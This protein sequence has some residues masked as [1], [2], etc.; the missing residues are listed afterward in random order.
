[1]LTHLP[2]L[3]LRWSST[4]WLTGQAVKVDELSNT[5]SE[6]ENETLVYIVTDNLAEFA[7]ETLGYTP[8][9]VGL[10]GWTKH[11]MTGQKL[12]RSTH[13]KKHR[14]SM[15]PKRRTTHCMKAYQ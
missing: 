1:M 9:K 4:H 15:R 11:L 5:L 7:I 13:L 12:R 14:T 3:R 8:L 6:V 2:S 10:R